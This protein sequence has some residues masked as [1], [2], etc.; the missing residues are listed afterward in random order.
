MKIL[1]NNF[2]LKT[3]SGTVLCVSFWTERQILL[4]LPWQSTLQGL[5]IHNSIIIT[6]DKISFGMAQYSVSTCV[7]L[8]F[9]YFLYIAD[10]PMTIN[11]ARFVIPQI[12]LYYLYILYFRTIFLLLYFWSFFE[13]CCCVLYISQLCAYSAVLLYF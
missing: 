10:A 5:K 6:Y 13:E 9:S 7:I 12:C 11:F 3:R 8:H 4:L 1:R 2:F